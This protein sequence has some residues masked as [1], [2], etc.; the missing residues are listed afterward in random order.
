[1]FGLIEIIVFAATVFFA[2]IY[3]IANGALDWG[4][5]RRVRPVSEGATRTSYST[6]RRIG[7]KEEAA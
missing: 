5:I 2:F 7:S 4:P 1:L 3:L 6:V